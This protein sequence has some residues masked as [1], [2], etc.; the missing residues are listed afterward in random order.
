M[1]AVTYAPDSPQA[2][3]LAHLQR[4]DEATVRDLEELLGISTTAVREHLTHLEARGMIGARLVRQGPGRPKLVYSLLPRAQELFPKEYGTLVTLLMRELA[5]S[6]HPERMQVLLDAVGARLAAE[7]GV[8]IG[9]GSFEDRFKRL[10]GALEERGIPVD[11]D[12]E[13]A[14]LHIYAC[15][16]HEVAQEHP[17]ICAM[18]RGMLQQVL[19]ETIRLEGAIREGHRSCHFVVDRP[20]EN[21]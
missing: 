17:A 6:E 18:E 19:G 11:I 3:I 2:R 15:P 16:Y 4:Q 12:A 8:Q 9:S 5:S 20:A 7:Y 1:T 10:R 21:K 13:Q 14:K